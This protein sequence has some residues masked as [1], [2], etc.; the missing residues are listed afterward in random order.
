VLAAAGPAFRV[1][2][3]LTRRSFE[4]RERLAFRYV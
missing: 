2:H 3:R 4:R 1:L